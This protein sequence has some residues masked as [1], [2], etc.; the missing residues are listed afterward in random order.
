VGRI[1]KRGSNLSNEKADFHVDRS[2]KYLF[3]EI[4]YD[5]VSFREPELARKAEIYT[6]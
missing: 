3:P 6:K 2:G 4:V 5:Q 1:S